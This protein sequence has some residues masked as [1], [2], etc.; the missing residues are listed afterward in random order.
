MIKRQTTRQC[1]RFPVISRA[2]NVTRINIQDLYVIAVTTTERL[3]HLIANAVVRQL[4]QQADP[5]FYLFASGAW[6]ND[7]RS[8][9]YDTPRRF[10][11]R[12]SVY[13][14]PSSV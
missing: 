11:C 4:T 5:G 14:L 6:S 2:S 1:K 7:L 10:T 12:S 3:S 9:L 8:L 13:D